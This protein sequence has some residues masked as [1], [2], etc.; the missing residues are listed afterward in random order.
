MNRLNWYKKAQ[1]IYRGDPNL[2]N[3]QD[4]DPEYGVKELGKEL[5]SSASEGPGIYFTSNEENAR[6]YGKNITRMKIN[7]ANILTPSNK[8]F[9]KKQIKKI[10]NYVDKERM[11]IAVSNWN[12]NFYEGKEMLI[13]SIT[14]EKNAINQIM[15][16][17]ADIYYHQNQLEFM[18]LMKNNGIDGIMVP[19]ENKTHYVIYNKDILK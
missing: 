11:R 18:N 8:P 16:I 9:S 15:N 12:E 1:E 7:N 4:F 5:G 17:W 13:N 6:M 3:I 19:K 10:L 2:I 14:D